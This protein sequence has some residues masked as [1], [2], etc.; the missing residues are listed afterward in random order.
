LA[1]EATFSVKAEHRVPL[2]R[3]SF[4]AIAVINGRD[5]FARDPFPRVFNITKWIV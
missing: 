1:F 4:P 5:E 2:R 3:G